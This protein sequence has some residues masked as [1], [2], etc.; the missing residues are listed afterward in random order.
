MY[1]L[2]HRALQCFAQDI[3]GEELWLKV[4]DDAGLQLREY[5]A[6]L[7]YPDDQLESVLAALSTHL[8]RTVAQVSEDVGA[9]LVTHDRMEPV[10]R[11]LR[12]GGTT[13]EEFVLSLDDLHDRVKLALPDLDLPQLEVNVHSHTSFSV[14]LYTRQ[15]GF[16]AVLLGILRA[17]G[18]DY[19]AL[20]VLN[21]ARATR[22][23]KAAE[24][25]TVELFEADFSSGRDFGLIAE[26]GAS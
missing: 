18:D 13:F 22:D 6:M 4:V 5:E 3:Y 26:T 12:F 21:L 2:V 15:P 14:V 9:Y 7:M 1:G 20:V 11:L 17:M 8:G 19:G 25:V 10:R 16:G 24:W 23:G